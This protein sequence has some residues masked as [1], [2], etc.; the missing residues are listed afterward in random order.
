MVLAASCG[1]GGS[2]GA[3]AG[4]GGSTATGGG[5]AVLGGSG[6]GPSVGGG[7]TGGSSVGGGGSLGV[8]GNG[9]E[10]SG[11]VG[12]GGGA[13]PTVGGSSSVGGGPSSGGASAGGSG[14]AAMTGGSGGGGATGGSP[15]IPNTVNECQTVGVQTRLSHG[16]GESK[17]PALVFNGSQYLTTWSDSRSGRGEIFA[18]KLNSDGSVVQ[19]SAEYLVATDVTSRLIGPEIARDPN[20]GY[21]VVWDSCDGSTT[22]GDTIPASV[23]ARPLDAAGQP[24]GNVT[25]VSAAVQGERRPYVVRAFNQY[26]VAYRNIVSNAEVIEI[27]ALAANGSISGAPAMRRVSGTAAVTES[28]IGANAQHLALVFVDGIGPSSVKLHLYNSDLVLVHE[29]IIVSSPSTRLANPVVGWN[30]REWVVAWEKD[31]NS[32]VVYGAIASSDATSVSSAQQLSTGPGNWPWVASDGQSSVVSYYGFPNGGQ[33]MLAR[34]DPLGAVVARDVPVS[35]EGTQNARAPAVAFNAALGE[36]AV[37]FTD[38][39]SQEVFFARTKCPYGAP[40]GGAGG[41]AG[42]GGA[43]GAGN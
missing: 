25:T 18:S 6:G 16:A 27:Q 2:D 33:A 7:K 34:F 15:P 20:A 8:G 11:G 1:G 38:I 40:S 14:G 32:A 23:R 21:L 12:V 24:T 26:F 30:G 5:G 36:F 41:A 28:H 43:G 42:A 10:A 19:G 22:C 17:H 35:V 3:S 13:S 37:V 39:T 4:S 31:P 9:A 29:A